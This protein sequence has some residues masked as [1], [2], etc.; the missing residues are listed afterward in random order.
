MGKPVTIRNAPETPLENRIWL[1]VPQAAV[2][3]A[4]STNTVRRLVWS[5][6]VPSYKPSPGRVVLKRADLDRY[7]DGHRTMSNEEMMVRSE[8]MLLEMEIR[9]RRKM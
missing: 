7:M 6:A 2:Y 1:S 8:Q 5:N 3:M 4:L 9:R